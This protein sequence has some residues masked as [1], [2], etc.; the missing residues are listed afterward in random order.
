MVQKDTDVRIGKFSVLRRLGRGGMGAV[1]EGYDPAL[2]RRVAI[3]TLTSDAISDQDSRGRFEREARAAAKLSHPNIVTVYELGNFGGIGKPYIVMEYLEGAD[4]AT[5]VEQGSLPFAEAL[6]IVIQLCRALDFAHQNGVVHRDVKPSN[7]RYLDNGQVKIMDFGIARLEGGHTYTKSGVMLGTVHYMSPE[8]IRGEKLDGRTDIF[9]AGCILYELLTGKRPF[10]GDTATAVLYNIVHENPHPVIEANRDLPQE[11]QRALDRALAKNADDRFSTA[12]EMAKELEKLLA[13][14]RKTLPRTSGATQ[15]GL[16][17]L[18]ALARR[19]QWRSLEEK[20]RSLLEGNPQLDDARRHLRRAGRELYRQQLEQSQGSS[21]DTRQL[22]EIRQELTEIYGPETER[23]RPELTETEIVGT[24]S[25]SAATVSSKP[26]DTGE[27]RGESTAAVRALAAPIWAL[28]FVAVLGI[29]AIFYW[30]FAREPAGPATVSHRLRIVSE[31]A[32]AAIIVDG[33][34][35]GLTTTAAGVEVPISGKENDTVLVELR[36]DGFVPA[37]REVILGS[38]APEPLS[39]ALE[40]A[41]RTF[42]LVTTPPGASVR[43]DGKTID[44]VTPLSLELSTTEKH[45]IVLTL[46]EHQSQ[47]IAIAAA[48]PLP[49]SPIVLAP[50]GRPGR[51]IVDS[52]YP[53]A[54]HRGRDVLA[55]ES[56]SP[57]IEL[58]PATYD[59]AL[60]AA[61]VFLNQSMRVTIRTGETVTQTTPSLGRVNVRANPGNCTVTINGFPAGSPPFMN[62]PIVE[63]LH[64]FVFTWPGNAMDTQQIRVEPGKPTYVIGQR[65]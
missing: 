12:G 36:R 64:E 44:G 54:I 50:L 35:I 47:T 34:A 37:S 15:K 59:L 7:L 33:R 6:D 63:G 11:V 46:E 32:G 31:P 18:D 20:A 53:V 48:D 57:R 42:E 60:V 41:R 62:K 28:F 5:I 58:R 1:Y 3:K 65:P 61:D 43:L 39:L 51:F 17:E 56:A 24:G 25:A 55:P 27:L 13:V 23:R 4:V 10:P 2:D 38:V 45:E 30:M 52:T 22:Q 26:A 9:S 14:Y 19:K 29:G 16:D 40:V 21:G 8:Q 49:G